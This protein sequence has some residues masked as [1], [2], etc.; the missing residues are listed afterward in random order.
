MLVHLHRTPDLAAVVHGVD[1]ELE[2]GYMA[3]IEVLEYSG[4]VQDEVVEGPAGCAEAE[5]GM[6]RQVRGRMR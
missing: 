4:T 3:K 1:V 6:G 2:A 5:E